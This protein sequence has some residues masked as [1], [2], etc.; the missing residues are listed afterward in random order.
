MQGALRVIWQKFSLGMHS[1]KCWPGSYAQQL[2]FWESWKRK[3][4]YSVNPN[5]L[6]SMLL[7]TRQADS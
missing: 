1:S 6:H 2:L 4:N 5:I 3:M 7:S